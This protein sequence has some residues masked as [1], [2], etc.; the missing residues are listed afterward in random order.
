MSYIQCTHIHNGL[1]S[2]TGLWLVHGVLIDACSGEA[3]IPCLTGTFY[4]FIKG[5]VHY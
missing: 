5:Y 2:Y 1:K 4:F 3:Y